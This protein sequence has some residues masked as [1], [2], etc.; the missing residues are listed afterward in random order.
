MVSGLQE[1]NS[2]YDYVAETVFPS[3]DG[4]HL[5][6][7]PGEIYHLEFTMPIDRSMEPEHYSTLCLFQ[8]MKTKE[9]YNSQFTSLYSLIPI[10]Y[11]VD[12]FQNEVSR[13]HSFKLQFVDGLIVKS[14]KE[15]QF[16]FQDSSGDIINCQWEYNSAYKELII[17]PVS[18]LKP[19][20]GYTLYVT[21]G[22]NS[23]LSVKRQGLFRDMKIPFVTSYEP[24]LKLQ[25]SKTAIDFGDVMVIDSPSSIVNIKE[26]NGNNIKME[27]ESGAKWI[28]CLPEKITA[29]ELEISIVLNPLF[30]VV[31]KNTGFVKISSIA[32]EH[33]IHVVANRLS[34]KYPSIRLNPYSL[35]TFE[36]TVSFSGKTDGYK[37]H[38]SGKEIEVEINGTFS[39][40]K[41]LHPGTNYVTVESKN[42]RGKVAVYPIVVVYIDTNK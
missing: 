15:N 21:G 40:D 19:N 13:D 14:I 9:I 16:Y 3:F 7:N 22:E 31:G 10:S 26:I 12:S 4:L 28:E 5:V 38:V 32:G 37:M 23:F 20:K 2:S 42:I 29:N 24:D 41:E 33:I 36:G 27:I 35:I 17:S 39:F 25:Y 18:L 11:D 8:N 34:D 30:M 6:L 1:Q